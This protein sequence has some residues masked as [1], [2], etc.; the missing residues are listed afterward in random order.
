MDLRITWLIL[1]FIPSVQVNC[2]PH[3]SKQDLVLLTAKPYPVCF[4]RTF[5]DFTCFWKAPVGQSFDFLYQTDDDAERRCNISQQE[6]AERTIVHVC[7]FP[8]SDVFIF[9][10]THIK[11][12]EKENNTIVY[13]KSTDV[14]NNCLL[15]P[16]SHVSLHHTGKPGEILVKWLAP[17][18]EEFT[19]HMQYE[20]RYTSKTLQDTVKHKK[21]SKCE[22]MLISLV[23]GQLCT[24]QIRVK[25]SFDDTGGH[26]SDW[27]HPVSVMVPQTAGDIE[28][29]CHTS[30]LHQVRCQWNEERYGH[31]NLHYQQ[32]DRNIWGNWKTC[33]K[34][35]ASASQ[36]VL[37]G[38]ECTVFQVYLNAT[39]GHFTRTFYMEKFRMNNSI[40]TEPPGGLKGEIIGERLCLRWLSPLPQI[41][42]HL[43]YQIRYQLQGESEWKLFTLQ[44]PS[45]SICLDVQASGQYTM[46]IKAIP[47]GLLYGGHWSDWS[48]PLTK[49][50]TSET[51]LLFFVCVPFGLLISALLFFSFSSKL[52]QLLWPPVPNLNNVLENFLKDID[53]QHWEPNIKLYDDD[54]PSVVEI[55]SEKEA[56]VTKKSSWTPNCPYFP[57]YQ[58]AVDKNEEQ[59]LEMNR[60][61]VILKSSPVHDISSLNGNDYVYGLNTSLDQL[62]EKVCCYSPLCSDIFSI[63]TTNILNHS[64]L[65]AEIASLHTITG[66]YTN[67]E[68]VASAKE[69]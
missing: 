3:L 24:V 58:L 32:T 38:D 34:S 60:E 10:S 30:D 56:Q 68:T 66:H 28:L 23:P 20:L 12:V 35:N 49:Q 25:I 53:G 43:I 47:N 27:S 15:N 54:V 21:G 51:W 18:Q 42:E 26:W 14:E 6:T 57:Q 11:V 50:L 1:F 44:N 61:Y 22:H 46:Q 67:L 65:Q 64:Y 39:F 7:F 37:Y 13:S 36:C 48:K 62:E 2:S 31:A 55:M 33:G 40:K 17:A 5:S 52:K 69:E 19:N 9:S 4:T 63:S 8:P 59:G 41:S 45:T 16:P 29:K